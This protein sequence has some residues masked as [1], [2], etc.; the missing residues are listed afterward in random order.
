MYKRQVHQGAKYVVGVAI[1]QKMLERARQLTNDDT[2][3]YECLALEDVDFLP[4][5]FD[6][7]SYTHLSSGQA[8]RRIRQ[9]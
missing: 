1:S 5:T 2:I 7:V 6:A 9:R 4:N 3:K 8:V